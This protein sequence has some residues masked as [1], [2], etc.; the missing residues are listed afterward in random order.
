M[1]TEIDHAKSVRDGGR[2]ASDLREAEWRSIAPDMPASKLPDRRRVRVGGEDENVGPQPGRVR[3]DAG[4]LDAQ[5]LP[6]QR[7]LAAQDFGETGV[8]RDFA[9]ARHRHAPSG[10]A[11]GFPP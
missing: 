5:M 7:M 8:E 11:V 10:G 3:E 6:P 4:P 1:W 2:Y 9:G